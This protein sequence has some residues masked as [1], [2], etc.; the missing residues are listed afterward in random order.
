MAK[1]PEIPEGFTAVLSPVQRVESLLRRAIAEQAITSQSTGIALSMLVGLEPPDD[2]RNWSRAYVEVT[3][4]VEEA[5]QHAAS[6]IDNFDDSPHAQTF[7]EI[8]KVF[9]GVCLDNGWSGYASQL[10]HLANIALPFVVHAT[11]GFGSPPVIQSD[12]LADLRRDLDAL[13]DRVLHS[14]LPP[15]FKEEFARNVTAL[16]DAIIRFHVYG[17]EGITRAAAQVVGHMVVNEKSANADKA[18]LKDTAELISKIQ[19]VFLKS[20]KMGKIGAAV[21]KVLGPGS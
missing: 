11:D 17:R 16:R 4:L 12:L 2:R 1:A 5:R 8:L 15:A 13:L 21:W 20:Y 7:A 19:D 6:V 3:N 9:G 18:V 14:S 10:N